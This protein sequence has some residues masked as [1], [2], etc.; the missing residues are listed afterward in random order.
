MA[1]EQVLRVIDFASV[2]GLR[3]QTLWHAVAT[4]VSQG[5]AP[6]LCFM[7]PNQA[8]VSLG[9]HRSLSEVDLDACHSQGLA[10][11]RR[12]VGG[13]PV[14]L[15]PAQQFFQLILP[16][17][18]VPPV[19]ANAIEWLL[20]PA[21][22]A[23]TAAGLPAQLDTRPGRMEIVADGRKVCGHGAGQIEDAMVLVGNCL[24][25]FDAGAATKTL[26]I[27][28]PLLLGAVERTMDR[29]VATPQYRVSA[30]VFKEV[31]TKAYAAAIGLDPVPGELVEAELDR[32]GE[33][34]R[35]FSS[36]EWLEGPL[37][38]TA[39]GARAIKIKGGVYVLAAQSG[40]LRAVLVWIEGVI[41][42]ISLT[43]S[44]LDQADLD[45]ASAAVTGRTIPQ[46]I[47][48]VGE[49]FGGELRAALGSIDQRA[50]E[51]GR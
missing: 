37:V 11:Y 10:V 27:S 46:A 12:M 14:Y 49:M 6:T 45:A 50:L 51:A 35:Q 13:G 18:M 19:R 28:D 16:M 21:A 1:A 29:F 39:R 42:E 7:R 41:D 4:G 44:F 26:A 25:S 40:S 3:S 47:G 30:E 43:G 23:L 17:S 34:D 24:E 8:Y 5:Q 48:D 15:D 22:E 31:A 32:L 33:L 38:A 20:G 36:A 9:Y 2:S